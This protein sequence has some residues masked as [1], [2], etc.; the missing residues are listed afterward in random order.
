MTYDVH[1]LGIA[2]RIRRNGLVIEDG[3]HLHVRDSRTTSGECHLWCP[4]CHI[5]YRMRLAQAFRV[6]QEY[7]CECGAGAERLLCSSSDP[8][9]SHLFCSRCGKLFIGTA[10]E[11]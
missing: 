2:A 4:A 6:A 1:V 10:Q 7:R 5:E 11:T 9:E 3:M 8:F